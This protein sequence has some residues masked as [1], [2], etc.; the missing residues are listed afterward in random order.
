MKKTLLILVVLALLVPSA[1]F[2]AAEFSL[3]GY[4]KLDTFWDSSQINKNLGAPGVA[5]NNQANFHH[6]RFFMSAQAS[7]FNFTIKGPKVWGATTTGFIEIDFDQQVDTL[8]SASHNFIPRLRHAMFRLNWP[9]TELMMGQYWDFMNEFFPEVANDA[10][11]QFHGQSTHRLAQIRVT[12]KFA[13]AFTVAGMIGAPTDF[14][15]GN[16][17]GQANQ[18][19]ALGLNGQSS[20][21]PQLQ[22]KIAYEKDLWGK[23]AFYGLPRGF[24][25]Q[26]MGGWQRNVVRNNSGIGGQAAFA[27][28]TFG[29]NQFLANNIRQY[30]QQ[31]LNPWVVQGNL[32]IPVIP[33]HSANLAG[34]ASLSVQWY[35]GA[36]LEAFGE[37]QAADNAFFRFRGVSTFGNVNLNQ[38]DVEL[39]QQY[40]GYVQGQYYF[41][42]QWYLNVMWSMSKA[43]GVASGTSGAAGLNGVPFGNVYATTVD[44]QKFWTEISTT[45]W[46]RPI[47]ALKFGLQYSYNRTDW[48]QKNGA[49]NAGGVATVAPINVK[50]LGDAHRVEFVGFMFF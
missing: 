31:Y 28:V 4:I 48:L 33:T 7:R 9:E 2:A 38:Y 12:Q 18:N 5:R 49:T 19:F 26:V 20:E 30:Q 27:G 43:F 34:T 8:Q 39:R 44:Q 37:T 11:P 35:V 13:G 42:N 22:G 45:L 16:T 47:Q 40:G 50:D 10:G 46:Y 1:A 17:T 21:T 29:Q 6:G 3:G 23:A 14:G 24:V 41:T 36:G 25:A 32:F 15:A